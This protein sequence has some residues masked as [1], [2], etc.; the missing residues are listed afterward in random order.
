MIEKHKNTWKYVKLRLACK[1]ISRL[2]V[3][4]DSHLFL[5]LS[6]IRGTLDSG[7]FHWV[8]KLTHAFWVSELTLSKSDFPNSTIPTRP[9]P[10]PIDDSVQRFTKSSLETKIR[11]KW[12]KTQFQKIRTKRIIVQY[13]L[14]SFFIPSLYPASINFAIYASKEIDCNLFNRG[15]PWFNPSTKWLI[16]PW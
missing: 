2:S 4:L 11:K 16:R 14:K 6:K 12:V 3:I 9:W 15:W 7:I 8:I 1:Q 13:V 5:I 10:V